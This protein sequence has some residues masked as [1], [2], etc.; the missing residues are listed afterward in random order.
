MVG[1]NVL[2]QTLR[3]WYAD[4]LDAVR[5]EALLLDVRGPAEVATGALLEQAGH[6]LTRCCVNGWT[7]VRLLQGVPFA[8]CARPASVPPSPTAS[9]C[10]QALTRLRSRVG[11]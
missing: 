11:C 7:S 10:R 4:D 3:L 6:P 5:A 1:E 9:W 8:S 2:N